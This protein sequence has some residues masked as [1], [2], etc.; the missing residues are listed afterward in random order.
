MP[1]VRVESSVGPA[2]P[3]EIANGLVHAI[4]FRLAA[5]SFGVYHIAVA[6]FERHQFG[7][8]GLQLVFAP[9][10]SPFVGCLGGAG[11]FTGAGDRF[12]KLSLALL[13]LGNI[14]PVAD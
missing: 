13:L 8:N 5:L 6:C 3:A 4:E 12:A 14:F 2:H 11:Q 9:A 10:A 7:D 1:A